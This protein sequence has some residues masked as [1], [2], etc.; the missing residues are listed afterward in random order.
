MQFVVEKCLIGGSEVV[1]KK[2][3][4]ET[5]M[6]NIVLLVMEKDGEKFLP[7]EMRNLL[8]MIRHGKIKG[9]FSCLWFLDILLQE[10]KNILQ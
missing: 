9:S 1:E 2:E 7:G 6:K 8:Y 3:I 4:K 10:K 5:S